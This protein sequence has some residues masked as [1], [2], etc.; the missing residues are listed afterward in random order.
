MVHKLICAALVASACCL[1]LHRVEVMAVENIQWHDENMLQTSSFEQQGVRNSAPMPSPTDTAMPLRRI[2][3]STS[4]K[5]I[6][7]PDHATVRQQQQHTDT[8]M[9]T[10]SSN[11]RVHPMSIHALLNHPVDETDRGSV[12]TTAWPPATHQR[13]GA[14]PSTQAPS[15]AVANRAQLQKHTVRLS[16]QRVGAN[17]AQRRVL[18]DQLAQ[19]RKRKAAARGN[20]PVSPEQSV[21]QLHSDQEVKL[22]ITVSP[23]KNKLVWLLKG[24]KYKYITWKHK[25][26]EPSYTT[27][28]GWDGMH[29]YVK[30][31]KSSAY[32]ESESNFYE[33]GCIAARVCIGSHSSLT[34]REDSSVSERLDGILFEHLDSKK[35]PGTAFGCLLFRSAAKHVFFAGP[36]DKSEDQLLPHFA[37]KV[38]SGMQ[39]AC[40]TW[41]G[42]NSACAH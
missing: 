23:D 15:N 7:H 6:S 28:V 32:Y 30:C 20:L 14:P 37:N 36:S 13:K 26:K 12:A 1:L 40:R 39:P 17:G 41:S 5:D 31:I 35:V 21:L 33:A 38:I 19:Q 8:R 2:L 29:Y 11:R 42:A 34:L 4:R 18:D 22:K 24:K 16:K 27:R 3:P 25:H 10:A 9:S